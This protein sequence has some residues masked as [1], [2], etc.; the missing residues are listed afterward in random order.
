MQIFW[1]K[2]LFSENSK[3]SLLLR[4][5]TKKCPANLLRESFLYSLTCR[6]LLV[7]FG[8]NQNKFGLNISHLESNTFTPSNYF[9]RP[10]KRLFQSTFK[11]HQ[12]QKKERTKAHLG[13]YVNQKP[14]KSSGSSKRRKIMYLHS[15]LFKA[16]DWTSSSSSK[17]TDAEI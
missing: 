15:I 16:S 2:W 1:G 6:N 8:K 17:W 11:N 4:V 9:M 14:P 5:C 13:G 10:Q 3:Y 7:T 12:Y